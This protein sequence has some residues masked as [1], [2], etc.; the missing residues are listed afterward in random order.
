MYHISQSWIPKKVAQFQGLPTETG[1]SSNPDPPIIRP[2]A[3]VPAETLELFFSEL[4]ECG[5]VF[6][7]GQLGDLG[8]AWGAYPLVN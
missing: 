5:L 6:C 7:Q 2:G 1:P 3:G 4:G 8:N